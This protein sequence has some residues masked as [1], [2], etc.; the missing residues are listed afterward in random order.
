MP[1]QAHGAMIVEPVADST[2]ATSDGV[3]PRLCRNM[4]FPEKA[5]GPD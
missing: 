3:S 5:G 4:C 2:A 1:D